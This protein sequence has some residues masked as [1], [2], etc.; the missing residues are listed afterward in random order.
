MLIISFFTDK[1]VPKTGL[2]PIINIWKSDGE[3]VVDEHSMVE[4]AGGFYDYDFSC[5]D[6]N[7]SY[8]FYADGGASLSDYDRYKYEIGDALGDLK[9]LVKQAGQFSL[10][11]T[12][13]N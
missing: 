3:L 10:L 9:K 2:Y 11:S 7:E 8:V 1:G 5:C 12:L 6:G 13:R 4:R